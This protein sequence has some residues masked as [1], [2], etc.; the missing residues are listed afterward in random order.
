MHEKIVATYLIWV[1]RKNH[2]IRLKGYKKT[3]LH[4][5]EVKMCISNQF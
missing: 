5:S 2:S 4:H 1:I 3:V